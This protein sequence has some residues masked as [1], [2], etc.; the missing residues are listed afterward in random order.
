MFQRWTSSSTLVVCLAIL[1][2]FTVAC[3]QQ[4]PDTRAADEKA[5]R[6]LDQQ[7]SRTAGTNNVEE[8]I[9]YY[10]DDAALLPPNAPMAVGKDAI[11][12][13]WG[14]LLGPNTN[15]SWEISK[16][17]VAKAGDLAYL[18]GTYKLSMKDGQGNP[19]SDKGKMIEVWKKQPDGKW[20]VVADIFNSDLPPAPAP[21]A[22]PAA[23][24][25]K[26]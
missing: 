22:A 12:K 20:K 1:M 5:V 7:W 11:R 16:L 25:E 2:L 24:S 19:I 3:N 26:K 13:V 14:E 4:P 8:T 6:E 15:V 10:S 17:E 18:Y 21:A 9:A 23:T